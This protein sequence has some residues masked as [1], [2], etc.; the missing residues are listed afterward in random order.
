MKSGIL[1]IVF[2]FC[3]IGFSSGLSHIHKGDGLIT[4]K[5]IDKNPCCLIVKHLM[6]QSDVLSIPDTIPKN[7]KKDTARIVSKDDAKSRIDTSK[8]MSKGILEDKVIKELESQ[9][10]KKNLILDEEIYIYSIILMTADEAVDFSV[11]KGLKNVKMHKDEYGR[12]TYYY[13]VYKEE[14]IAEESKTKLE[15]RFPSAFVFINMFDY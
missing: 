10:P 2:I 13:G 9:Q 5:L 8:S 14:F 1:L 3:H 12:Y 7:S 6:G 11:F 4:T 15:K